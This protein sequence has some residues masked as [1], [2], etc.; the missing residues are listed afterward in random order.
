MWLLRHR[1]WPRIYV[2][3]ADETVCSFQMALVVAMSALRVV[4]RA[5]LARSSSAT[6]PRGGAREASRPHDPGPLLCVATSFPPVPVVAPVAASPRRSAATRRGARP[7]AAPHWDD[8][9]IE[10]LLRW[11]ARPHLVA[12]TSTYD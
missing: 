5:D 4:V 9:T 6:T 8:E 7:G 10:E 11:G 3:E 12:V 1:P 2:P